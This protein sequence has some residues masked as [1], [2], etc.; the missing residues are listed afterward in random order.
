MSDAQLTPCN[1]TGGYYENCPRLKY[2]RNHV[3]KDSLILLGTS[4]L[5][6]SRK[7]PFPWPVAS[8]IFDYRETGAK[9]TR[10]SRFHMESATDL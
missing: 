1:I 5:G 7:Y 6:D 4:T 10:V 3:L 9:N 2:E 8:G